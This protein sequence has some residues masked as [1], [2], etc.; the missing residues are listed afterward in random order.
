MK[1]VH[2]IFSLLLSMLLFI[3]C[4]EETNTPAALDKI[5]YLKEQYELCNSG[6]EFDM[7]LS[8]QNISYN[9]VDQC[10]E[11]AKQVC[12]EV[13]VCISNKTQELIEEVEK[14]I[15]NKTREARS[16]P[17]D[18]EKKVDKLSDV[19]SPEDMAMLLFLKGVE[20]ED[21]NKISGGC[22]KEGGIRLRSFIE[23]N[24]A[25]GKKPAN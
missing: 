21:F 16:A 10:L 20:E 1:K 15:K 2:I 19:R 8:C 9:Y 11:K 24:I 12:Q 4:K 13:T 5:P 25:K 7:N 14:G 3:H 18:W 6:S 23:T 17:P 22:E